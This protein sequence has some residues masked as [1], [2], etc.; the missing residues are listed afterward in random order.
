[1]SSP[2]DQPNDVSVEVYVRPAQLAESLDEHVLRLQELLAEGVVGELDVSCWP[3]RVPTRS[4]ATDAVD[5]FREFRAWAH[6]NDVSI[7]PPFSVHTVSSEF[8]GEQRTYLSTPVCCLA[9]TVGD[10]IVGVYPHSTDDEHRSLADGIDELAAGD[11]LDADTVATVEAVA[12]GDGSTCSECE[13][14]LVNVQGIRTCHDCTWIDR[15]HS[16]GRAPLVS[17]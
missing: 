4:P 8:T 2:S 17:R 13:G 3:G 10:A 11:L 9:V 15:D 1:M 12:A 14:G 6:D 16:A 5:R 7:Q